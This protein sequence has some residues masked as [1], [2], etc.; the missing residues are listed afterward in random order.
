MNKVVH[1][2]LPF[3]VSKG[4]NSEVVGR[5][6]NDEINVCKHNSLRP[7]KGR[8]FKLSVRTG[9]ACG[10]MSLTIC[11]R[12]EKVIFITKNKFKK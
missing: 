2:L 7:T 1:Y 9:T 8:N 5:L 10:A 4:T 6:I 12:T 3:N 11:F